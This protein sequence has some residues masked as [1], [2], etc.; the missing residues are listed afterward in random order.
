MTILRQLLARLD[1]R[2]RAGSG[3]PVDQAEVDRRLAGLAQATDAAAHRLPEP[4]VESAR[5]VIERARRRRE[6]SQDLTVVALAGSTG[7]GKST[8]FNSIVGTEV[9]HV[10]VLRP[11]TAA[12]MAAVWQASTDTDELL[13]WLGVDRRHEVGDGGDELA[14]LVLLDLPDHDSTHAHHRAQVDRLVDRADVMIWVMDPQKYADALVH[15]AYLTRFA[16][17]A[18]VTVVVLNQ[19][20]RLSVADTDACLRHLRSLVA[21]DGLDDATVLATSTRSGQGLPELAE[22][23]ADA[24]ASRRAATSRLMADIASAAEALESAAPDPGGVIRVGGAPELA[25]LND[26]LTDAAGADLISSAVESS[27]N[28]AAISAVGWPPL[29]WLSR[30][31]ADP[32]ARLRLDRPG[33]D[34]ALVRTSMPSNDPVALARARTAVHDFAATATAGAPAAWVTSTR[35]VAEAAADGLADH[36]DRAVARAPIAKPSSPRWWAFVGWLQWGLLA[37]AVV[38]GGWLLALAAL[39]YLQFEPPPTPT[40]SGLPIPTLMLAVGLLGGIVLAAIARGVAATGARRA[41][42]S[43]REAL[44]REVSEVAESLVVAPIAGEL[45]SLADFRLGLRAAGAPNAQPA[46]RRGQATS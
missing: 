1:P 20:D 12:P 26:A 32:I 22:V 46:S 44:R 35:G 45:E 10:G 31:R 30:R 17:H 6:L 25:V 15:E 2:A 16:R 27:R 40:V 39:G 3:A 29:R 13:D 33:V 14:D 43:A 5:A 38:G 36:L 41:A 21:A 18:E 7:A 37:L 11:T 19:V 9:A 23:I 8:L 28:R 42:R 24:I 4:V 34:P